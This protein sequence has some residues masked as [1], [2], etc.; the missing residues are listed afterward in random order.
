M[1]MSEYRDP[2]VFKLQGGTLQSNKNL[3][4]TCVNCHRFRGSLTQRESWR[5]Q[6]SY[7]R[8][9]VLVEPVGECNRYVDARLPTL[10]MMKEIAWEVETKRGGKVVGFLSPEDLRKRDGSW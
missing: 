9:M 1:A 8:P 5:C 10:D 3:C 6:L 4:A 7:N 2:I